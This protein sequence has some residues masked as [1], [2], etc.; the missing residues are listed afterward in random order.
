MP[1]V[2]RLGTFQKNPL[3]KLGQSE[4]LHNMA[5]AAIIATKDHDSC[6]KYTPAASLKCLMLF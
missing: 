2:L 5:T 6:Q 1:A 4:N 3:L